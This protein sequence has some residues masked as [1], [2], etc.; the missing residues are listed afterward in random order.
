MDAATA[1][2]DLS[3]VTGD[4]TTVAAEVIVTAADPTLRGDGGGVDGA[5]HRAAGPAVRRECLARYPSGL[6]PGDAGWTTAGDLPATWIVHAVGPNHAGRQGDRPLLETCYRRALRVADELGARSAA[7]PVIGA[8]AFGWP[9][10]EAVAVAVDTLASTPTR[11]EHV[12]LVAY[13]DAVSAAAWRRMYHRIPLRLLD[14]VAAL[15]RLGFHRVRVLPGVS[16]SGT[17]WRLSIG[18]ADAVHAMTRGDDG[19]TWKS[20]LHYTS[21][22]GP[23]FADA[24]VTASWTADQVAALILTA[25][26]V[27]P[28]RE[29]DPAYVAWYAELLELVRERDALPV[30]YEE[31]FEGPGWRIGGRDAHPQPPAP[32]G[33]R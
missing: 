27:L 24:T 15:H 9:L 13:A 19:A 28:S 30:A 23:K 1:P 18:D 2:A 29:P 11:L 20:V 33:S 4:I 21:A 26:P 10:E 5:V 22:A 17:S 31:H 16:P 8:G 14:G 12:Q 25:L 3:I 6:V 32:P 7:F